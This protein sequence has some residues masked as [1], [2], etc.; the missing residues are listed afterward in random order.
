MLFLNRKQRT[1]EDD[2]KR[3]RIEFHTHSTMSNLDGIT[4]VS[5][6]VNQAKLWGHEAIAITDHD[7]VYGFP[8]LDKAATI[9]PTIITDEIA[10]VTDING[11]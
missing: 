10:L 7:G 2:A 1:R 4:S 11:V 8:E 3:K 5:D 9:A 6:Y